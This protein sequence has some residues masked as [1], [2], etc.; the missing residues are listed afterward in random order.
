MKR[1]SDNDER[2]HG[3][4]VATLNPEQTVAA[5]HLEGPMLVLAGP[6]TG[7][8]ATLAERYVR[9]LKKG[10]QP[11][12]ILCITFTRKAAAQLR[13]RISAATGLRDG[14]IIAGTFH[15]I[16][17]ALASKAPDAFPGLAGK[18]V[19]EDGDARAIFHS[20][21]KDK[22]IDPEQAAEAVSA[23]K[24]RLMTPQAAVKEAA[25]AKDGEIARAAA[26]VYVEYQKELVRSGSIDFGDMLLEA[27]AALKADPELA[28]AVSLQFRQ[29]MIDEYQDLNPAQHALV[30][31]L[32][33]AHSNLWAVGDDDQSLYSWRGA[34]GSG[35]LDFA[36]RRPGAKTQIL[37][38]NYR[39]SPIILKAANALIAR[40]DRRLGKTLVP[41]RGGT[42]P[43][44]IHA[45]RTGEA[46]AEWI[47]KRVEE[48]LAGGTPPSEIAILS[49]VAH[50]LGAVERALAKR[51][52][53]TILAGAPSFWEQH[54]VKQALSLVQALASGVKFPVQL[55]PP[56]RW[57]ID[58]LQG[59]QRS[60]AFLQTVR[61]VCNELSENPPK[62]GTDEQ[63]AAWRYAIGQ[64]LAE[65]EASP[66]PAAI[67]AAMTAT[68]RNP[69][70]GVQACTIHSAKGLEW[71]A[72]FVLGWEKGVMPHL[73][74]ED[75]EEERRLAYVAVTRARKLLHLTRAEERLRKD[76]PP[77]PF[78][79]E[80]SQ[81]LPPGAIVSGGKP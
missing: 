52:I 72:V 26:A 12:S 45:A 61:L 4:G 9:L 69:T 65:V 21:C 76:L 47:A 48:L 18:K 22:P 39:S 25:I 17:R 16:V 40:N 43:I 31:R 77:S 55:D 63:K 54:A 37:S 14:A 60:K 33:S 28:R 29:L 67:S 23:W 75:L 38:R 3:D 24:D 81:G 53:P 34:D 36:K 73:R 42:D 56:Q 46:E 57:M 13:S 11:G 7:K 80:L 64:L 58:R 15:S 78:L 62:R 35:M 8:T 30:E 50:L 79:A 1:P 41:T 74:G 2:R 6:G 32:L 44:R 68:R 19:L 10:V 66:D 51:G 59:R 49:R 71:D 20:L 5:D 27:V 70:E